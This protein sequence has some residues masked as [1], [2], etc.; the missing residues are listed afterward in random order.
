M[1]TIWIAR[2]AN[3]QDFADPDWASSADRPHDPGL[4][5]DGKQQAEKLARRV[6]DL[7][8]DQIIASPFRRT[9]ETAHQAAEATNLPIL[10]EPGL[11]EWQNDDWFDKRADPLPA[12]TLAR[13]FKH[14]S[15]AH[16]SCR[17]PSF[18]ETKHDALA[19][20]GATGRCLAKRYENE[21]LFLVG[22][23]ITVQGIL[24]GLI[25]QELPDPGCPLASLTKV[26]YNHGEWSLHL[27]NDTSH[28]ENGVHAADRLI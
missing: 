4:A 15:Q 24:H 16:E 10:L 1:Q 11:G 28:L 17:T 22:H 13:E 3:R 18:P 6:S 5:P 9:I 8:V 2:H 27:R 20:I 7:A 26:V 23:G 14:I 19:R 12:K 25:H 21:T